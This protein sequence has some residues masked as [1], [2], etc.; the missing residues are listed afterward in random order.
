LEGS[1]EAVPLNF[2]KMK[3]QILIMMFLSLA[4]VFAGVNNAFGQA[5][6]LDSRTTPNPIT[7]LACAGTANFLHPVAGVSYTYV[8]EGVTGA[9]EQPSQWTWFATKDPSFISVV[10]GVPTLNTANML[11]SPG[12]LLAVGASYG[13]TSTTNSVEITWSP[14]ILA[15]TVY[16]TNPTFV[17]GYATGVNCADNIQVYEIN[18]I[19]NFIID[20]ANIESGAALDWEE[21]TEQCVDFVQSAVY[22][23][24]TYEIDMD[25]GKDTIYFEVV[26][27]N[28]VNDWT[29]TFNLV[30]GLVGA[31][32]AE[33]GLATSLANAQA[34]TFITGATTS[35]TA[36]S[37]G[38]NW[39]TGIALTANDPNTVADGVSV[40]VRVIIS[41]LTEESLTSNAFV[42]AVD[43]IDDGGAGQWDMEEEDC[44]PLTAT[45]AADQV[46]RATH[47]VTPRPTI[48]DDSV[49][50]DSN[51]AAPNYR[52]TK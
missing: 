23:S 42:L 44:D 1:G 9:E 46:D 34:G 33:V 35:W 18:P 32:T 14:E 4:F 52:I 5:T 47:T 22:N 28:F 12:D 10:G 49:T 39:A 43:A 11:T 6:P 36:A 40:F 20:I 8:M 17:V 25:Y 2:K 21:A 51:P 27:A 13:V 7:P 30:S 15:N 38:S 37:V 19:S 16:Q 24:G 45:D 41:N 29:P 26:A 31:Q 3:K 48:E 50:P